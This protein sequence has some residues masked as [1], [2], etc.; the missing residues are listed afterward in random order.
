MYTSNWQALPQRMYI[1]CLKGNKWCL[2]VIWDV[3][4]FFKQ[5]NDAYPDGYAS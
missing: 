2:N 4:I 5:S 3:W 1:K